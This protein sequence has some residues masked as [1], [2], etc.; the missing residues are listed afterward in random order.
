MP[1]LDRLRRLAKELRTTRETTKSLEVASHQ[2]KHMM[3][4]EP[5]IP[6]FELAVHYRPASQVS[7]DF[8]DFF[9]TRAGEHAIV[10][11]D[12]TGH[13][14]EAAII[15]GMA[16]ATVSVYGRQLATPR[17]VLIA[18]NRDLAASLDG[19]TFVCL[20]LMFLDSATRRVRLARAGQ[21][22]PLLFNSSWDTPEP[23]EVKSKGLALGLEA[24]AK[25][26]E[27]LEEAEFVL[28]PGDLLLQYTDGIVEATNQD[29]EQFGEDRI[30]E[31]IKKY[32]RAS[33][34][35]LLFILEET[36]REFTRSRELD[37]DVTMMALKIRERQPTRR[38][39]FE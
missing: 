1:E 30:R 38:L 20:T 2:Q 29:K 28:E 27:L 32:P 6:N 12:V 13:G 19:M 9:V 10:I 33:T 26:E 22:R 11:A 18:A 23:L 31:V 3:P 36:L 17:E 15:M 4:A 7:G 14:V 21:S 25:F 8:Y 39:P 5:E 35:E 24:S 34:R 37:D 16:K